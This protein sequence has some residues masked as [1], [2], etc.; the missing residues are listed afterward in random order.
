M[1]KFFGLVLLAILSMNAQAGVDVVYGKDTR[2]D[3]YQTT[4]A[5][6]VKLAAST[7]GMF[8]VSQLSVTANKNVFSIRGAESLQRSM[9]VCSSEKF[10]TQ[11][12]AASCSGFLV[13]EDTLITAG[14]CVIDIMP[15]VEQACKSFVWAFDYSI[16]SAGHD[17]TKAISVTDI[18]SCKKV[19]AAKLDAMNDYAVIKLDRKV[20]GRAPLKFRESGKVANSSDLVVIGHPSGLPS[21][22]SSGGKVLHNTHPNQ[23]VTSL[24]TF[25]GNSGSAVFNSKTGMIEGILVQG[26]I[27]YRPSIPSNP[28]SCLVVNKCDAKGVK[29]E[30]DGE[31]VPPGEIVTRITSLTAGIKQALAL[32]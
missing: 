20:V 8:H 22:I 19:V 14:H 10:A 28:G 29:C 3:V 7:A 30:L 6:H 1:N 12:A 31:G 11:P 16:K 17:P 2:K 24:D 27:D 32:K 26:K 9:N 25:Q 15:T 5:L 4:N 23:F 18:Y 13:G 21:K